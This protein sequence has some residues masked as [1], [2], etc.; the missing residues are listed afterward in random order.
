[1]GATAVWGSTFFLIRDLVQAVPA[2]DFL[3][4]RFVLSSALMLLLWHRQLLALTRRQFQAGL[5]LGGIYGLA[6]VGQT[7]GLAHTAASVSGFVTGLYVVL[8]PVLGAI[9]LRERITRPVAI[10]VGLATAGLAIIS[11]SG[12]S[13]GFG[14]VVTLSAAGLYALHILGLARVSRAD[15]VI[16]MSVA[17]MLAI[18][19]VCL[20]GGAPSGYTLPTEPKQWAQVAYMVLFASIGALLVQTWAQS[21]LSATRAAIVM[22]TEPVFA[23]GFAV[24]FGGEVL[25]ARLIIGGALVLAA[26]YAV[27]LPAPPVIADEAEPPELLHHETG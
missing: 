12:V 14:E 11:L 18:T 19:V 6:Q 4:L 21:Q 8:T 20:I 17:Q 7:I 27:E 16:G 13:F 24:A 23:A 5:L 15:V 3:A 9:I 22:T 26:M 1:M 2:V 10:A 25:T